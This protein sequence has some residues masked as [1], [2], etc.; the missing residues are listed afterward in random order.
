MCVCVCVCVLSLIGMVRVLAE[1]GWR[2][3]VIKTRVVAEDY[4][5]VIS[6]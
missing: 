6:A 5:M 2:M 1:G 4:Y 3:D